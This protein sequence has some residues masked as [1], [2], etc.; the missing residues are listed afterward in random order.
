MSAGHSKPASEGI[1]AFAE[2]DSRRFG[3]DIF[4]GTTA[5]PDARSLLR[6]IV[7][8][9]AD[10]AIVRTPVGLASRMH[11]L[12]A[13][14]LP[15]IHADTLVYYQAGLR[16]HVARA[17]RNADLDI[18]EAGAADLDGL[19][20]VAALGFA[21]YVSHYN[22]NPLLDAAK[23]N[24]GY[25]EW[26]SGYLNR[27]APAKATWVARRG[28][29]VLGFVCCL[30]DRDAGHCEIVL[31]A[32][33]PEHAGGGVYTDLVR[34]VM[35]QCA[36]RGLARIEIS[37]QI[38]N[39]AV[40]K[41]WAREGFALDR[42]YDTYH[43]NALLRS[44][45]VVAEYEIVSTDEAVSGFSAR[46]FGE[47]LAA[48]RS[49]STAI[50]SPPRRDE[51]CRVRVRALADASGAQILVATLHGADADLKLLCYANIAT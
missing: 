40:Q 46:A 28:G 20:Q 38:W 26:A 30:I 29:R 27:P 24:A 11:A 50:V 51:Q 35:A 10:I 49:V 31:N 47:R 7:A 16:G 32:V 5:E 33:H 37:T 42:A 4:R 14:G 13:L 2:P 17:A 19:K 39:Y 22:A 8:A 18:G 43:L 48:A 25:V 6:E 9:Q 45:E 44:G 41:V 34:H 21:G 15:P 1:L 12:A 36:A 3:L 23:S